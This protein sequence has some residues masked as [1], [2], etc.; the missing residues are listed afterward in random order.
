[1][2]LSA[3][4]PTGLQNSDTVTSVTLV[5]SGTPATA[6]VG[7]Y[8]ITASAAVGTGLS[9]YTITYATGSTVTVNAVALTIT[10]TS[11]SKSYGS[12]LAL[13]A[14]TTSGLLT[15]DTVT[16]VTLVS[17]GTPAT[18]AVGSYPITAS[19]AVGTGL[20]NYTI[21][22]VTGHTVTVNAAA[23]TITPTSE[24]KSYGSTLALSAFTPTGLQNSDTVTSV[25]LTSLGTAVLAVPGSYPITATA[26]VGTGLSN[27]TITYATGSTVTVSKAALVITSASSLN[28]SVFGDTV[29]WTFTLTGNGAIP[30]GTVL[31]SDGATTL[32]TVSINA[33]VATYTTSAFGPGSHAL[34][35]VYNG[36]SNYY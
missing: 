11:Q 10:P 13:S 34:T 33:G 14:F 15:S 28:P 2:A 31:I 18:A 27:Y 16:S 21:T 7:S 6:A 32:D 26:A 25:T 36:D 12:T 3:F 9:N 17:S 22:Y 23:L 24:P 30:T 20:S 1:L 8:P 35:A 19:A 5:S 29:T 4:T